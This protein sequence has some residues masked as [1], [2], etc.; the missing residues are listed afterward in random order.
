MVSQI[1]IDILAY[2]HVL[3]AMAWLGGGILTGFV[4]G[5]SVRK[6]SPPSGLE[7]NSKVL[8]R[9]MRF[10]QMAIGSTFVFGL[11]LMYEIYDGNFS[12]LMSTSQGQEI[13]AGVIIGVL[14][15]VV[16]FAVT[17]PSFRKVV[18]M[19]EEALKGSPPMPSPGMA[20]YGKRAMTGAMASTV[21]LLLALAM[22]IAAGFAGLA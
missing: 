5:P 18:R 13:S 2:G 19:S 15:A 6:L 1:L 22:M 8:P 12:S 14:A 21:L 17:F 10:V 16:G 9:V 3:S 11:L 7:F 20:K 4:V